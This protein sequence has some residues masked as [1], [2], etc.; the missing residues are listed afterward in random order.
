M[1]AHALGGDPIAGLVDVNKVGEDL[2]SKAREH[3]DTSWMRCA[4]IAASAS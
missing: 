4:G 1:V 2:A 3:I